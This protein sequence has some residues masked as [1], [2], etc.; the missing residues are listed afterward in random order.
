MISSC[1][2]LST[3]G[4]GAVSLDLCLR[5]DWNSWAAS[6][7]WAT[8]GSDEGITVGHVLSFLFFKTVKGFYVFPISSHI[9]VIG[10]PHP[11]VSAFTALFPSGQ[12]FISVLY[13]LLSCHLYTRCPLSHFLASC[14]QSSIEFNLILQ[15][16]QQLEN[17][18]RC[19]YSKATLPV[20]SILVQRLL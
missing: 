18:S 19:A 16:G 4:R 10:S 20:W 17:V 12:S 14:F 15:N 11:I 8:V 13:F 3:H 2:M 1:A 5:W 7:R 6:S 9:R